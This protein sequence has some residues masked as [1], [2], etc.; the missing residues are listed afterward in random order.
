[1]KLVH[2]SGYRSQWYLLAALSRRNPSRAV[3]IAL[4]CA[5]LIVSGCGG[6]ERQD[7][8]E[9]EG[10]FKVE[11][12][13]AKFPDSQSLAKRSEMVIAVKNVDT[14]TIPNAAVTVNSFDQRS[15]DPNLADPSRPLFVLNRGPRGGETAYVGTW[16]LG[17]LKPGQV[18]TFNWDVTAV[19]AGPYKLRYKVAAG[20]AGKAKAVL[21]SGE[22]PA[23]EFTGEI[24][25][26]APSARVDDDGNV[27]TEDQ[28]SD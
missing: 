27:V 10:S 19:K 11:I 24:S 8:N 7:K 17:P 26:K 1:M 25:N 5:G 12:V 28:P 16:A 4:A 9:P 14:R 13:Q 15:N 23:G 20:L 21:A 18:K 2:A 6:G 22:R 3:P